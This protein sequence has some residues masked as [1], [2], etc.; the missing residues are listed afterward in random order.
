MTDALDWMHVSEIVEGRIN[1]KILSTGKKAIV[2]RKGATILTVTAIGF[3][4]AVLVLVLA[5][6]R[7]FELAL[8]GTGSDRN[9]IEIRI[10]HA[11]DSRVHFDG[12]VTFDLKPADIVR[13]S[14]SECSIGLL[15]PLG[16]SY[17]A[18]LREKLH[19]SEQPH[20]S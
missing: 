17:F 13:I 2:V 1:V 11:T 10:V 4:V 19:W 18:M 15:H 7:G 5:L 12:Q 3:A 20:V 14:R 6:A 9:A 16:Y 8:A